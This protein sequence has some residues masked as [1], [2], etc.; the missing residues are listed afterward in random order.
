[1]KALLLGFLV[2]LGL[3]G[4]EEERSYQYQLEQLVAAKD[5][6]INLQNLL[7]E[8]LQSENKFLKQNIQVIQQYVYEDDS[9]EEEED[10]PPPPPPK[11]EVKKPVQKDISKLKALFKPDKLNVVIFKEDWCPHC[12]RY[13]AAI[14]DWDDPSL[15]FI[16]ID[17][18]KDKELAKF[19]Q[20]KG[21][22]ETQLYSGDGKFLAKDSG[23]S[24]KE[25]FAK[26]FKKYQRTSI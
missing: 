11:K 15:N 2:V 26:W 10:C 20:G 9:D 21:I 24:D 3:T 12:R 23:F 6:R 4:C 7:I 19:Q 14:K 13:M 5:E 8:Q 17:L 1:M 25:S 18:A 22:P 16:I